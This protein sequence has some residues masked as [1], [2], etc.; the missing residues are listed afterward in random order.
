MN[1][2]QIEMLLLNLRMNGVKSTI[3]MTM[4]ISESITATLP[5][6]KKENIKR[7]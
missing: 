6:D 2:I 3:A 4:T 1:A 7:R 5:F